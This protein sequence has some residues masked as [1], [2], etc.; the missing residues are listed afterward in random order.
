VLLQQCRIQTQA[1]EMEL[2]QPV[3]RIVDDEL[4]ATACVTSMLLPA[5]P[6]ARGAK[7]AGA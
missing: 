1:I 3:Q 6:V 7:N 2:L 4:A 5:R